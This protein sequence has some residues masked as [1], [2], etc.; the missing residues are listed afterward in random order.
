MIRKG[1]EKEGGSSKPEFT[2]L[3]RSNEEEKV[4]F[5]FGS[6]KLQPSTSKT[7]SN[8]KSEPSTSSGCLSYLNFITRVASSKINDPNLLKQTNL[9]PNILRKSHSWDRLV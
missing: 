1:Q 4:A 8:V 6:S 2:E 3:K 5:K 9:G 7:T